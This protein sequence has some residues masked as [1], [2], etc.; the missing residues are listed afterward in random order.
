MACK[1]IIRQFYYYSF[2]MMRNINKLYLSAT[3]M[4]FIGIYMGPTRIGAGD[5]LLGKWKG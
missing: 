3:L 5:G 2:K 4:L 1:T